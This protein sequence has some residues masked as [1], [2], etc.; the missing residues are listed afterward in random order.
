MRT[1]GRVLKMAGGYIYQ[2]RSN[3]RRAHLHKEPSYHLHIPIFYTSRALRLQPC[4]SRLS[5]MYRLILVTKS[6]CIRYNQLA[7]YVA[8]SIL[9]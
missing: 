8:G 2:V 9:A 5:K 7:R 3:I 1:E 6:S 4:F